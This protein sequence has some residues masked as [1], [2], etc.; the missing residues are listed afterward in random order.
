MILEKYERKIRLHVTYIQGP[1][2]LFAPIRL[3]EVDLVTL[4]HHHFDDGRFDYKSKGLLL[5]LDTT[6]ITRFQELIPGLRDAEYLRKDNEVFGVPVCQGMY[7]LVYNTKKVLPAPTSWQVLWKP[8]HKGAY[9]IGAN[10]YLYNVCTT[11]LAMGYPRDSISK[12]SRLDNRKFRN[13]LR[14]LALNAGGFW[15]GQDKADDLAGKSLSA[16]WGDGLKKLRERGENWKFAEPEEGALCWVDSY[17]L[18]WALADK[19]FL[20]EVAQEW[21]DFLLRPEFQV[22]YAVRELSQRAVTTTIGPRLTEEERKR[23]HVDEAD[24]FENNCVLLPTFTHRDRN[25]MKMLWDEAMLG[26]VTGKEE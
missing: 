17:A 2:D 16:G 1:G 25:G 11:A 22:D 7:G 9:A 23:L 14:A 19:P 13:K 12:Y 15:A 20:R 4:T 10:E 24:Y 8:E 21:I 6:K 5:P 3:K 18:T 26:I